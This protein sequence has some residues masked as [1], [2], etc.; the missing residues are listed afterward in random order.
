M[1]HPVKLETP[2]SRPLLIT[3]KSVTRSSSVRSKG[4][5]FNTVSPT[6]G[7]SRS[8]NQ[9]HSRSL[10]RDH[11][12]TTP[13]LSFRD[14]GSPRPDPATLIDRPLPLHQELRTL[15]I[16]DQLRLLALKEMAVVA[17]NDSINTLKLKLD[18][19]QKDLQQLR[20]VI[21]KSLYKEVHLQKHAPNRQQGLSGLSK[22]LQ[23]QSVPPPEAGDHNSTIWS[24][25]SKPINFLQ[26]LD[27]MI[28]S[29]ME[30]SLGGPTEPQR[31]HKRRL[32]QEPHKPSNLLKP[33]NDTHE[34]LPVNLDKY[35]PTQDPKYRDTDDMFQAVSSSLWSF[36][37]EVKTNM[38]STLSDN[39]ESP[40][41]LVDKGG[42][43]E[44][45][46][47][48]MNLTEVTEPSFSKEGSDDEQDALDLSMY[49]SM[50]QLRKH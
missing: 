44:D 46:E 13:R 31:E 48:I 16:D 7:A 33:S 5:N 29:E 47:S 6:P 24:N 3:Q 12:A 43:D 27:T 21:Q 45:E 14:T 11:T 8:R 32:P 36:V 18:T 2:P 26:Q 20:N 40:Q 50:R 34:K 49:S 10:P 41:N 23:R 25:L 35:F 30:K 22:N 39:Q 37:S 42:T 38:M 9:D 17:I 19:T 1:D 28:Q 15:N 4:I